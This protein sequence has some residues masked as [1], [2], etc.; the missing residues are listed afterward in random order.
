MKKKFWNGSSILLLLFAF[1]INSC[2]KSGSSNGYGVSNPPAAANTI[3][4]S[5]SVFS[6]STLTVKVGTTI[7]WNNNDNKAHTVTADDSSFDSGSLAAGKSYTRTFGTAG[8]FS[9]HCNFHSGM[10]GTIVVQP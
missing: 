4:L 8:S 6:P 3:N 2:S 9:Y 10:T 1:L 5:G 7:T